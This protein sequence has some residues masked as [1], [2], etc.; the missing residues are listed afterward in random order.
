MY[1]LN[2]TFTFTGSNNRISSCVIDKTLYC[3]LL[4]SCGFSN[5][6]GNLLS[7]VE[8]LKI[9]VRYEQTYSKKKKKNSLY[10]LRARFSKLRTRRVDM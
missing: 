8:K 2:I 6:F 1:A 10:C 4:N 3:D 7:V 9:R 5:I